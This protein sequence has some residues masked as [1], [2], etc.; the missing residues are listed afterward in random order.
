MSIWE[1]FVRWGKAVWCSYAHKTDRGTLEFTQ[2]R[3]A[4]KYVFDLGWSVD[5][6]DAARI[7]LRSDLATAAVGLGVNDTHVAS[8]FRKVDKSTE[9]LLEIADIADRL[10]AQ[11]L[12]GLTSLI[13]HPTIAFRILQSIVQRRDDQGSN[14]ETDDPHTF[15]ER[16]R[17]EDRELRASVQKLPI[18][19]QIAVERDRLR[20]RPD[21]LVE[22]PFCRV[23]LQPVVIGEGGDEDAM[24]VHLMVHQ[25]GTCVMTVWWTNEQQRLPLEELIRNSIG[26]TRT[27]HRITI[28]EAIVNA[29]F[30]RHHDKSGA[31]AERRFHS[32]VWWLDYD[33]STAMSVA[34]LCNVY[35][36]G[37]RATLAGGAERLR[38]RELRNTEWFIFPVVMTSACDVHDFHTL[39]PGKASDLARLVA[40]HGYTEPLRDEVVAE[41]LGTEWSLSSERTIRFNGASMTIVS[42]PSSRGFRDSGD[43]EWTGLADFMLLRLWLVRTVN[44]MLL[45]AKGVPAELQEPAELLLLGSEEI[46]GS[47]PTVWG[48]ANDMIG[49]AGRLMGVEAELQAAR[50]RLAISSRIL[51]VETARRRERRNRALQ[52]VGAIVTVGLGLPALRQGVGLV[53]R[54]DQGKVPGVLEEVVELIGTYPNSTS[55]VLWMGLVVGVAVVVFWV[56]FPRRESRAMARRAVPHHS[57]DAR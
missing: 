53:G 24:D 45:K 19:L 18:M 34:D 8:R 29:S 6:L 48:T 47:R 41:F 14:V 36:D 16:I 23:E 54:I 12:R 25:T 20:Y 10:A 38:D 2:T 35:E 15:A 9:Q 49:A 26:G 33:L 13:C 40:R 30:R 55:L 7:L 28:A 22:M 39:G 5:P 43:F 44:A 3:I 27:F 42:A 11:G 46:F 37:I 50:E 21:Y 52:I 1:R 31:A 32:G 56:F 17:R 57:V 4:Y 51:D